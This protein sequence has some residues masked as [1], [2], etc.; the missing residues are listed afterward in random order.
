LVEAAHNNFLNLRRR[1]RRPFFAKSTTL[2]GEWQRRKTRGRQNE[3]I[4]F[5]RVYCGVFVI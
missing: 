1:L 3:R 4:D 2:H 5:L